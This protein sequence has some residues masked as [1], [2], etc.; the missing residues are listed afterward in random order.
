MSKGI[1]LTLLASLALAW[2][3]GSALAQ[4][5]VTDSTKNPAQIAILRWY[6]ANLTTSFP[7]GRSAS[8]VTFDGANLWVTNGGSVSKL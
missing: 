4:G 8:G 2:L 7:V 6:P 1:R 3:C 5:G